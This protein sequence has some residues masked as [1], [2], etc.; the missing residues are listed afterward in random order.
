MFALSAQGGSGTGAVTWESSNTE[1]ADVSNAGVVTV[2]GTGVEVTITATKAADANYGAQSASVTFTPV[3]KAVSFK[4]SGLNHT[5]SGQAKSAVV[6]GAA[7]Y[8]LSYTDESGAEIDAP[9]KA[10]IY[11]VTVTATGNYEG[12]TSGVMTIK[13]ANIDTNGMTFNVGN[14]TYGKPINVEKPEDTAY[15]AGVSAKVTYTGT[16]IYEP[17]EEKPT[18]AGKYMATLTLSG[19]NHNE[20]KLTNSFTIEKAALI[21][22]PTAAPRKYGEPNPIFEME[23]SG[24]VNGDDKSAITIE[25]TAYTKANIASGIGTYEI[26]ASGGYAENYTFSYEK[27][28]LTVGEASGGNFHIMGGQTNPYVGAT[29]T[30]SAYY[31]NEKAE[32][33]WSSNNTDVATVDANGVVAVHKDGTAA[34][35]AK[36]TDSRFDK[37]LTAEF[38]LT[39]QYTPE[40]QQQIYFDEPLVEKYI[41][42]G[43]FTAVPSGLS[44]GATIKYIQTL[45]FRICFH[46]LN[47]NNLS[48]YLFLFF[49]RS[50]ETLRF[51]L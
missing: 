39:A 21:A 24:F 30:L 3:K 28:T 2:K 38:I 36:M 25:P 43:K 29:F 41:T 6:T 9:T 22:K 31:N 44:D 45:V 47:T 35:T 48:F 49:L 50:F 4:L 18:N 27:G 11:Y 19:E 12:G 7:S 33:S 17:T 40:T 26:I 42:D 51:P 23:Y 34:I 15:P 32:V 14:A 1:I 37:N 10:G 16:G 20:T 5:Y 13:N 46:I 8:A